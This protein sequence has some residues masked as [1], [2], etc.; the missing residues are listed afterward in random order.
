MTSN[1]ERTMFSKTMMIYLKS[2]NAIAIKGVKS[3]NIDRDDD[4]NITDMTIH[5]SRLR[6]FREG[7]E[8]FVDLRQIEAIVLK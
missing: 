8:P 4:G 7:E 5:F 6:G 1:E 2:G 3:Y